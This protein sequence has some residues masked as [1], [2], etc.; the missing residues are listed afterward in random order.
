MSLSWKKGLG[1]VASIGMIGALLAGCGTNSTSPASSNGTSAGGTSSDN[2]KPVEGGSIT[3]DSTQAVPDL[4]PAVA[5]DTTSAEVDYAVYQ[6]L[7]TYDKGSYNI[8]GDLAKNWEVSQDGKTYTFHLRDDV[9]YSNGDPMVASDFVFELERLLDKKMQPKPS[10]GSQF[11]LDIEGAQAYYDGQAKTISGVKT[12]DDHTLVIT[13]VKPEQFFLKILAMPFLSAVDPKFVKQVGNAKLDTSEAM[14]TGPFE[15]QTNNQNEVVLVRNPNYWQKDS[16]GNKLP[17]LDKVTINVNN[18]EQ[19]DAL[20]WEQG[21]TAFMSPWLMGGDGIPPSAYPTI[22]TKYKNDVLKQ[23][24][25]SIY[26]IGLNMKPTLDGK[27]NPLSNLKVRQAIEYATDDSQFIKI[28]NGAVEGLNQPLPNTMEGYVKNLDPSATYK[29]DVSKAK[30]LMKE[31]G[32]ANGFTAEYWNENN[33]TDK[34]DDQAFQSMLSQIGIKLDIHEVTWKDFLTKAMSGTAQ[35]YWSGWQQDFPDPSDFLNTL[36]NS[37]QIEPGNNMN[38]YSNPQVDQW[39]N[40]AEYSTDSQ[41]RDELYAKVINK[42]MS[43]AAWVPTIQNVG[44]Y[45]IQP[46]VHGFYTSPVMYDPF[47]TIWVD[48]GHNS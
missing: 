5:F 26:Y 39:L 13:L 17:Y 34:K 21:Q 43:D 8:V 22:M 47:G 44:Y 29:Y 1:T 18:N 6:Q 23:P 7:V 31:A 28:N 30:E 20:H 37:N 45:T 35:M 33:P 4:D 11:F 25:N 38:N 24:Q 46:W 12:P 3:L 32:Y 2:S 27:P 36:F 42:V 10:P 48:P 41:Q 14:G 40:E 9:K 19:V 15:V 16:D